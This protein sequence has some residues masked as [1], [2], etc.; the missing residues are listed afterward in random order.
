MAAD[1]AAA[2]ILEK[3]WGDNT[4]YLFCDPTSKWMAIRAGNEVREAIQEL[5]PRHLAR[6]IPRHDFLPLF[7][8]RL[9]PPSLVNLQN[10][11]RYFLVHAAKSTRPPRYRL[12]AAEVM[13]SV[14]GRT[15]KTE[16]GGGPRRRCTEKAIAN[17]EI[18]VNE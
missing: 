2:A 18:S 17:S 11:R 7:P 9:P 14:E 6:L 13:L 4:D 8:R 3:K 15:V 16:A 5:P 12:D 10:L 1:S